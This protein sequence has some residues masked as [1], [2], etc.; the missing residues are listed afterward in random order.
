[1][2]E[3][4]LPV[5]GG[6]PLLGR[7]TGRGCLWQHSVSWLDRESGGK[8]AALHTKMSLISNTS[9]LLGKELRTEFRSRELLT[10]TVVFILMIIV[11]FSFTFDPTREES[12]HFGPGLLWLAFLF[13][14]SLMLQPGFL[15]EQTNDTLSALR[16]SV[17]DPFAIF[18]SKLCANTLFLLITELLLLPIFAVLYNVPLLAVMPQLALVLFLGSLGLSVTG[19]TL[20]AISAQARMRELLLPLLLLPLL[21]PLLIASTEATAALFAENPTLRWDWLAF[22]IAFDIIFL[23]AVWLFGEYLLEE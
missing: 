1:V 15:R 18:L 6:L 8:T 13:A 4:C 22:L 9:V 14:A 5:A 16:L 10:T 12:R 23:T 17:S 11:L 3:A 19:T 7:E 21:T 2:R 20:S